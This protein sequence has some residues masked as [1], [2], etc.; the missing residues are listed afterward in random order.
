V[1]TVLDEPDA[2]NL[3]HSTGR[4]R[5]STLNQVLGAE[6]RQLNRA[7]IIACGVLKQGATKDGWPVSPKSQAVEEQRLAAA[8]G[9]FSG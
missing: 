8:G 3:R 2:S 9:V 4:P 6:G 1:L 7:Y 5:N